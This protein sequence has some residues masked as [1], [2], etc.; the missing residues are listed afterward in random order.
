M[1]LEGAL[2]RSVLCWVPDGRT[3][4]VSRREGGAEGYGLHHRTFRDEQVRHLQPR[5]R[6]SRNI[7]RVPGTLEAPRS[8]NP[9]WIMSAGEKI[10]PRFT[11]TYKRLTNLSG[12]KLFPIRFQEATGRQEH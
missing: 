3:G 11:G 2:M 9:T 8:D 1:C 6:C 4:M 10:E 5:T 7:E 12:S